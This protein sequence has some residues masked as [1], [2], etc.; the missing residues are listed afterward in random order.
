MI[1]LLLAT[2]TV[3][4]H[5]NIFGQGDRAYFGGGISLQYG[6]LENDFTKE[7]Y[8]SDYLINAS[9]LRRQQFSFLLLKSIRK[10]DFSWGIYGIYF[11]ENYKTVELRREKKSIGI[12][13]NLRLFILRNGFFEIGYS[14]QYFIDAHIVIQ[15][16][17]SNIVYAL[18]MDKGFESG[19]SLGLGYIFEIGE[20]LSIEPKLVANMSNYVKS[21]TGYS[22]SGELLRDIRLFINIYYNLSK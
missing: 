19:P 3:S 6:K 22:N 2:T 15:D 4:F 13:P 10:I 20:L 7:L 9:Y 17:T 5:N 14:T 12:V 1:I 8:Y 18:P 16:S 21:E 11:Q